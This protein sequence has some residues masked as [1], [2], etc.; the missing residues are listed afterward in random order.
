VGL[1]RQVGVGYNL[2]C[3]KLNTSRH[4][5]LKDRIEAVF[6]KNTDS[7]LPFLIKGAGRYCKILQEMKNFFQ[8][9]PKKYIK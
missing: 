2:F 4:Y 5:T 6:R 8:K 9:A 7:F 3:R 1:K